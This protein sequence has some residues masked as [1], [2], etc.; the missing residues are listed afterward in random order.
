MTELGQ[1]LGNDVTAR[2]VRLLTNDKQAQALAREAME[3]ASYETANRYSVRSGELMGEALADE[4]QTLAY[5]SYDVA[6]ETLTPL[7][8]ANHEA[9]TAVTNSIQTNMNKAAG[10]GLAPA[11]ME[12]DTSRIDGLAAV[13][14]Q[15]DTTTDALQ[16]IVEP[17]INSSQSIVDRS[18]RDNARA[19]SKAGLHP[20]IIRRTESGGIR[21]RTQIIRRGNKVYSYQRDYKVPCN[22]C[23]NLAGTYDYGEVRNTGNDVYRRHESCR[24]L[25]TY[26]NG[27]RVQDVASKAEWT[28]ENAAQSREIIA[29]RQ[30]ELEIRR[31]Q[32]REASARYSSVI[33]RIIVELGYSE[34]TAKWWYRTNYNYILKYGLDYMIDAERNYNQ[35]RMNIA[36]ARG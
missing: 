31:E 20:V 33:N 3:S 36:R 17:L 18:I 4:T 21:T 11:P 24:C 14:S 5:M 22:W 34:K 26:K 25:I 29:Q 2:F 30:R 15:S 12:L 13:V 35:Q 8:T 10:V 19:N 23:A 27:T 9:V 16:R 6:R 1:T 32:E 7:M 28:E